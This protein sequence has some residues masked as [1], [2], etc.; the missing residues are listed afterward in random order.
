MIGP[1]QHDQDGRHSWLEIVEG[2]DTDGDARPDTVEL[3]DPV[4]LT[5]VVD[6]D[7][8]GLADLLLRIGADGTTSSVD[9][10]VDPMPWWPTDPAAEACYDPLW[11]DRP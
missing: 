5:F 6:T 10:T 4:N 2:V 3:P 11:T 8:D 7:R 9:L 1:D